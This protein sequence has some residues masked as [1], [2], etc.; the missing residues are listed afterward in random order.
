M[1]FRPS[2]GFAD[3]AS[4][5]AADQRADD[6][7]HRGGDD[8]HGVGTWHHRA[9]D[10]TDYEPDDHGPDEMEH[11]ILPFL[12]EG[13]A[14]SGHGGSPSGPRPGLEA[15]RPRP[16]EQG[17]KFRAP[18]RFRERSGLRRASRWCRWGVS[19]R[20]PDSHQEASMATRIIRTA[21]V[22]AFFCVSAADAEE[23][24]RG[25]SISAPPLGV[26]SP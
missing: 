15:S 3:E 12:L 5:E 11:A 16:R 8:A 18:G 9:R 13:D 2:R 24:G 17:R 19:R 26:V 25:M 14:Q 6:A 22:L 21:F 23:P 4:D 1:E 20:E 10:Q 7:H